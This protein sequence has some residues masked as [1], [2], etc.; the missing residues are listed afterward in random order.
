MIYKITNKIVCIQHLLREDEKNEEK[1]IQK[2][3]GT[4]FCLKSFSTFFFFFDGG[5]STRTTIFC[6]VFMIT[7]PSFKPTKILVSYNL[8]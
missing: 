6:R 8:L 3:R 2:E 4:S 5:Y 7:W 1:Q